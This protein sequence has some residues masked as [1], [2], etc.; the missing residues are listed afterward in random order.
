MTKSALPLGHKKVWLQQ[1]IER[2]KSLDVVLTAQNG[3][4]HVTGNRIGAELLTPE[5]AACR[6]ELVRL[7]T[8]TEAPAL[9][10]SNG[11]SEPAPDVLLSVEPTPDAPEPRPIPWHH[12]NADWR[13][14][15]AAW[16]AHR[17]HCQT[18]SASERTSATAGA[19]IRCKVGQSL[20][21]EYEA[22]LD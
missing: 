12:L 7:L 13:K 22:A 1:L 8:P 15:Y 16:Q 6:T 4:L 9:T 18:C 11:G 21:A 17:T 3:K 10:P 2:A 19:G 20:H 14:A 5:L